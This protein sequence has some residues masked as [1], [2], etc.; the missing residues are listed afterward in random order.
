MRKALLALLASLLVATPACAKD[1]F[2]LYNWNNYIAPETIK[3]FEDMCKCSVV[4]TYY[5]DNEE[6]LAKLRAQA[7]QP[8]RQ[9]ASLE[10]GVAGEKDFF[11]T[12]EFRFHVQTF[13]GALP[14]L[15]K[16]SRWFLSR[17]VSIGCQK[18]S[19]V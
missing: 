9:P 5:S 3:R 8:Q 17:S 16:A 7:L 6:L 12:P 1:V 18:P 13:Q 10:A 19:C 2:H 11:P 14:E 15:H 4:Q